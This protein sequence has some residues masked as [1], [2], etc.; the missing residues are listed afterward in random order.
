M[1]VVAIVVP[2]WKRNEMIFIIILRAVKKNVIFQD[3]KK[4]DALQGLLASES[5]WQGRRY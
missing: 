1:T 5:D 4:S 2:V 3:E